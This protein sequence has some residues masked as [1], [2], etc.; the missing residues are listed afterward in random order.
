ME[1]LQHNADIALSKAKK[2]GG[3]VYRCFAQETTMDTNR[4]MQLDFALQRKA[5]NNKEFVLYFQPILNLVSGDVSSVE[6][7]VRWDNPNVGLISPDT[8]L[9]YAEESGLILEIGEWALRE[10]CRIN[11]LWQSQG[12]KPI[13]M[14][15]NLSPL[16]FNNE[17]TIQIVKNIL[18]ETGLNPRYLQLEITETSV[19]KNAKSTIR[20]LNEM[21]D[22]GVIVCL[23]DFGTGFSS[24]SYFKDFPID[25]LKIDKSFIKGIPVNQ[26]DIAITNA[27]IALGHNLQMKIIAEGVESAEQLQYL[28]EHKC[29][30]AQGYYFSRPLPE[31]KIVLHLDKQSAYQTET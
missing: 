23:D 11:K 8:F 15:V 17:H 21:K 28:I 25:T 5:I 29:N 19:M 1:Y 10:A 20:I 18:D 12:Y 3:G 31:P 30:L 6:A 9:P 13:I 16:Q 27:I 22:L 7:L 4:D 26:S 14:S 24:I 2:L